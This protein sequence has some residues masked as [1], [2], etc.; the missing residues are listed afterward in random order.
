MQLLACIRIYAMHPTAVATVVVVVAAATAVAAVSAAT[1]A[2]AAVPNRSRACK[3]NALLRKS[4]INKDFGA[5]CENRR[6]LKSSIGDPTLALLYK[7][8][9]VHRRSLM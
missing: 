3:A 6:E 7:T 2:A 4:G 9:D 8:K 5:F 1:A